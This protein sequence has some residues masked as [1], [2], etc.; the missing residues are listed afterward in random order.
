MNKE[1][2]YRNLIAQS[3]L[4]AIG[5]VVPILY[6][7]FSINFGK[8]INSLENNPNH[9]I[10]IEDYGNNYVKPWNALTR[11]PFQ[12]WAEENYAVQVPVRQDYVQDS[13]FDYRQE[14]YSPPQPDIPSATQ[15]IGLKFCGYCG[16]KLEETS[17][18]CTSCGKST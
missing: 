2:F 1:S 11:I 15:S 14:A 17:K 8:K 13:L 3:I 16:H 18:F 10:I 5:F 12:Q 7:V 6:L 4:S 9:Y